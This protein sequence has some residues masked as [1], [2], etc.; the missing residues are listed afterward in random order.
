MDERIW[1]IGDYALKQGGD[2]TFEGYVVAVFSKRRDPTTLRLVVE[3]AEGIL[4]IFSPGNL[5]QRAEKKIAHFVW[6]H[7]VGGKMICE[8][9]YGGLLDR[10]GKRTDCLEAHELTEAQTKLSFEDLAL[11]Y[12]SP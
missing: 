7:G 3:N 8:I 12:P 4:H 6:R 2:Y 11:L 9:I 5:L 1:S 10:N